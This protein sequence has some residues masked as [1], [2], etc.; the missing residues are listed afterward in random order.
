MNESML[1]ASLEAQLNNIINFVEKLDEKA[2]KNTKETSKACLKKLNDYK[3]SE[4]Y[5]KINLFEFD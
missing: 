4:A 2:F 5:K 3:E 1:L